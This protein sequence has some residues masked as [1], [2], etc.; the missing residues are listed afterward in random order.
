MPNTRISIA[1]TERDNP[2][3][4]QTTINGMV[5]KA[6]L[7]GL[8]YHSYV[9]MQKA[10]R[11]NQRFLLKP[12]WVFHK[13]RSAGSTMECMLTNSSIIKAVI[14]LISGLHPSS[15]VI[16]DAPIQKC[17]FDEIVT[18]EFKDECQKLTN[19][20]ISFIDFREFISC[21]KENIS[22]GYFQNRKDADYVLFDLKK[23]SLLEQVASKTNKFQI[24]NYDNKIVEHH[25]HKGLHQYLVCKEA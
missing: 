21:E 10:I 9:E 14:L 23:D 1:L 8:G 4:D 25:H 2:Y 22:K 13:T 3:T 20:K 19:I 16:G 24:T 7:Q 6:I 5:E 18:A 15:I 11:P 17:N 12:N